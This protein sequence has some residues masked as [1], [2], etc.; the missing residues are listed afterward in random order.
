MQN[1]PA[2][3][4]STLRSTQYTTHREDLTPL[5]LTLTNAKLHS[6]CMLVAAYLF[7][8]HKGMP[9]KRYQR[10][11]YCDKMWW[12]PAKQ[13]AVNSEIGIGSL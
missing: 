8:Y 13:G 9:Q 3:T 1:L 4:F 5:Q 7:L 2:S 6:P 12:S 10:P 11:A